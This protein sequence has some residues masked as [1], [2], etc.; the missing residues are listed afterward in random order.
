MAADTSVC[1]RLK[2]QLITFKG[3]PVNLAA[4]NSTAW[5]AYFEMLHNWAGEQDERFPFWSR[6]EIIRV[7]VIAGLAIVPVSVGAIDAPVTK[8]GPA[9]VQ[10]D[11]KA[12]AP[13]GRLVSTRK[14]AFDVRA[15]DLAA[16]GDRESEAR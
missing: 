4:V 1:A 10:R 14:V 13:A 16:V 8:A 6:M 3:N 11:V 7:S 15:L 2:R 5:K 12:E 9:A